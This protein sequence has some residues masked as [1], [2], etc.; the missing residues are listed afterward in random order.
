MVPEDVGS[1]EDVPAALQWRGSTKG[2][3]LIVETSSM[4]GRFKQA[5]KIVRTSNTPP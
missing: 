5:V 1:V 3:H 2:S 4:V